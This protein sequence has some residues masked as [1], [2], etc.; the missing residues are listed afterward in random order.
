MI[1]PASEAWSSPVVLVQKQDGK[2]HFCI[3][4]RQLNARTLYPLSRIDESWD[5]LET[6]KYF[7]TLNLITGIEQVLLDPDEQ[8]KSAFPTRTGLWKWKV[9]PFGWT[10]ATFAF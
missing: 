3:D 2:C 7:S 6:S 9:L 4:Y 5:A 10:S 1:E 8:E